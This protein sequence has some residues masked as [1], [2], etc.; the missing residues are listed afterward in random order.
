M[1]KTVNKI[2]RCYI[3]PKGQR[4]YVEMD[5]SQEVPPTINQPRIPGRYE[6]FT[7]CAKC[8]YVKSENVIYP[9]EEGKFPTVQ[10]MSYCLMEFYP[11]E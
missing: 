9:G 1:E 6:T 4:V 8:G 10:K 3:C 2:K 7:R 5:E 11:S